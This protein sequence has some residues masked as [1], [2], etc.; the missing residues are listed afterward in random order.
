MTCSM[1][2]FPFL[3]CLLKFAQTYIHWGGDAIQPSYSLPTPSLLAL[4]PSQQQGLFQWVS[5][6]YQVARVSSSASALPM[7]IQDWFLLGWTG[8][9]SLLSKG[10]WRVFS[11]T[12]VRKHQFFDT[13]PSSGPAFTSVHTIGKTIALTRWTFVGKVISLLCYTLSRFVIAFLP[14][15]KRLLISW[16][17]SLS[18]VILE[19]R[20]I[21]SVIVFAFFHFYSYM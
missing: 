6:S 18:A 7:N 20:K 10:L 2:G 3:H 13:Q 19:P 15:S 11:S 16:L 8:W 5:C 12:T 17:Q 1:P 14:R 9:I 21:K 4:N